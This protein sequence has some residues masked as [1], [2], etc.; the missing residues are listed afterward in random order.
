MY[1]LKNGQ[2][3]NLLSLYSHYKNKQGLKKDDAVACWLWST[4]IA[5]GLQNYTNKQERELMYSSEACLLLI[6]KL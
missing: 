2:Y 3:K 4:I 5:C 1:K 6:S